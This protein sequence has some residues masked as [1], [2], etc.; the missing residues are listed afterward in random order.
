MARRKRRYR[1][2]SKAERKELFRRWRG[3]ELMADISRALA[4]DENAVRVHLLATGGFS[5]HERKRNVRQLGEVEREQISRG[6]ASG[7]SFRRIA[8][9]LG[10]SP[11]T[12]SR[13]VERNG[14]RARQESR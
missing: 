5:P 10:R 9:D 3:G 8:A 4:R 12:I 14:G 7:F 11:S 6:L 2:F 1:F 13:E